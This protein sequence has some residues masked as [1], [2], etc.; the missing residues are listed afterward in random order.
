MDT[1]SNY[2][3]EALQQPGKTIRLFQILTISP[4]ICC[5]LIVVSL[6]DRPDYTTLSYVW[7]DPNARESVEVEGHILRITSSLASALR[8]VYGQF[9]SCP[10]DASTEQLLWADGL[11]I[12]QADDHEKNYQVPLMRE[13]YSKC[14]RMF[15]WLG[16]ENE[17]DIREI[18]DAIN[19]VSSGISESTG[20]DFFM[21]QIV[22]NACIPGHGLME[23]SCGLEYESVHEFIDLTW[24]RKHYNNSFDIEIDFERDS[25]FTKV[26][27][28][29]HLPYWERLWILQEF[30][31]AQDKILLC[32]PKTVS[33][34]TI[35][36][37]FT[38]TR[39]V[40]ML[41]NSSTK[42]S[43]VPDW[44]WA[45]LEHCGIMSIPFVS[46]V[47]RLELLQ[48]TNI[49]GTQQAQNQDSNISHDSLSEQNWQRLQRL[50]LHDSCIKYR[51][52]D[53]KD[54]VYAMTG[55]S[56]YEVVPDYS[57][58][59]TVAEVYQRF[60]EAYLI[61]AKDAN[62]KGSPGT[63]PHVLWFFM[64][65]GMG[66]EWRN[67][68]CLPTW[69]PDFAGASEAY[70]RSDIEPF[71]YFH[72]TFGHSNKNMGTRNMPHVEGSALCC[73]TILVDKVCRIGPLLLTYS[74][75]KGK[76]YQ[77]NEWLL[78][79]FDCVVDSKADDQ[80][81][82]GYDLFFKVS[83]LLSNMSKLSHKDSTRMLEMMV[84]ELEYL[85]ETQRDLQRAEFTA[86]LCKGLSSSQ[87]DDLLR[88]SD[89]S[90]SSAAQD[91]IEGDYTRFAD[92]ML[93]GDVVRR[94]NK[95]CIAFTAS[96]CVGLLP[97]LARVDDLV[98]VIEGYS[99]PVILRKFGNDYAFVGPCYIPGYLEG[100]A[101]DML[102]DGRANIEEI[103]IY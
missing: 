76:C 50:E 81:P 36:R 46:I 80:G 54:Y 48:T 22:Q 14:A 57:R 29:F 55:M 69:A 83:K 17:G 93:Y 19:I 24:L 2:V 32:G 86:Q 59:T 1:L 4:H 12:N 38:W 88:R 3:Y 15:S 61:A 71:A 67:T 92:L 41:Y 42:P 45:V 16:A 13:I 103:R 34:I 66:F 9:K 35:C 79:L 23:F 44:E 78:Q 102:Q 39:L 101:A 70:G 53:P 100:E 75:L 7:G 56:G 87:A 18:L 63:G 5:K 96:G 6:D 33:W 31:L 30:V 20:Y 95:L 28:L 8:D 40:K 99:L 26:A 58:M 21:R 97:P 47:A 65:A 10:L 73:T 52:T 27:R 62:E 11:C 90:Y 51:A 91:G 68:Q 77:S 98:G 85:C 37:V 25:I 94:V 64:L 49:V 60:A 89:W 84:A 43:F 72:H 82:S 74:S